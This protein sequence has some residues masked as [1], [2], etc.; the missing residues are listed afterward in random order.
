MVKIYLLLYLKIL[1]ADKYWTTLNTSHIDSQLINSWHESLKIGPTKLKSPSQHFE[2]ADYQKCQKYLDL[3]AKHLWSVNH[4]KLF[5]V[6]VNHA[7]I[8]EEAKH[9]VNIGLCFTSRRH[10]CQDIVGVTRHKWSWHTLISYQCVLSPHGILVP[11]VPTLKLP[12]PI[13]YPLSS[14]KRKTGHFHTLLTS[15]DSSAIIISLELVLMNPNK[16]VD[17]SI[18]VRGC[19]LYADYCRSKDFVEEQQCQ[20]IRYVHCI[21]FRHSSQDSLEFCFIER[22]E[23][24]DCIE[25]T[26]AKRLNM[27]TVCK[28]C[29][30]LYGLYA[31]V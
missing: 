18:Y 20:M 25:A 1:L 8:P 19:N 29:C 7:S 23:G 31:R 16:W 14:T 24:I 26:F 12:S 13:K 10:I 21:L 27:T 3:Y 2:E 11:S 30:A 22:P 15:P 5:P 17:F 4:D 28:L 6:V 9:A